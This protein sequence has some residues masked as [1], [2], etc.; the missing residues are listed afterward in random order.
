MPAE[1]HER[2]DSRIYV[3]LCLG[4]HPFPVPAEIHEG[5]LWAEA[6]DEGRQDR[7]QDGACLE[8]GVQAVN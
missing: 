4:L 7:G 1:I 5:T 3:S 6:H 2:A 8:G